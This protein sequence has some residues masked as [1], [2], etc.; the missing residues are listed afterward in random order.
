MRNKY[1][2]HIPH[3]GTL[4]PDG[5]LNDYFLTKEELNKNIYEYAD[6]KTDK[7]YKSLTNK[8]DSIINPYSR[9]FFDPERFF[10][11]NL[12]LMH[13]NFGLGWFY[14]NSIL[15]KRPLRNTKNKQKIAKYYHKHH[16]KLENLVEKKLKLF[17]ECTILDCHSFSNKRYWFHDKSLDLPDICIGYEEFHKDEDLISF[18]DKKFDNI[19]HNTPYSG[20]LV[21]IKY[22]KK[23]KRVKSVMIEVNKKLYLNEDNITE[24]KNIIKIQE[25]LNFFNIS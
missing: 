23:D 8:C 12:E 10:D 6:Y 17:G 22:Y 11:D 21:P 15:E 1:I 19:S 20:S 4:I 18:Y 5:F 14:E 2:V 9:L 16:Q 7:L 3:S 25:K 13:K 24:N